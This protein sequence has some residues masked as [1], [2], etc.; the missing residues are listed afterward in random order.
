MSRSLSSTSPNVNH[1]PDLP[2]VNL[3]VVDCGVS[4]GVRFAK[5]PQKVKRRWK[6]LLWCSLDRRTSRTSSIEAHSFF[7]AFFFC[8]SSLILIQLAGKFDFGQESIGF[9]LWIF[10]KQ[11]I[12][13]KWTALLVYK[14]HRLFWLSLSLWSIMTSTEESWPTSTHSALFWSIKWLH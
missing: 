7:L 11:L 12:H 6:C 5:K 14:H 9:S 8:S 2:N 4:V 3:R 13:P 1:R 10:L